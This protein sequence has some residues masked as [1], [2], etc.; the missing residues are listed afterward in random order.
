MKVAVFP[1]RGG[2]KRIPR[3]NVRDFEGVPIL[4]RTIALARRSECFDELYVST[5]DPGIAALALD[6]GAKIIVRPPSLA[7]DHV[8]TQKVMQHAALAIT[9]QPALLCC[10]YPTAVLITPKDL[11]GALELM[12]QKAKSYCF[13]IARTD[14]QPE[15]SLTRAEDGSMR[16]HMPQHYGLGTQDLTSTWRDAGQFYWGK[17]E[18]F[19]MDLP[20]YGPW[21]IGFALPKYRAIDI[22]NE[23]DWQLAAM[24]WRAQLGEDR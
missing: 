16:M 13:S 21:A 14:C 22:D 3:K 24:V 18:A 19:E 1:A 5:E 17:R 9:P 10:I 11:R 7:N 12:Q 15:R 2:S 8:G 6:S 4:A 20:I 23:E